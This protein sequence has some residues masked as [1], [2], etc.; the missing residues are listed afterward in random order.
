M[1]LKHF[2]DFSL[3]F[4]NF[5]Q[6]Y[7]DLLYN[8]AQECEFN[9]KKCDFLIFNLFKFQFFLFYE[10]IKFKIAIFLLKKSFHCVIML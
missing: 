5:V 7:E 8:I 10:K 3:I 6:E 2:L 9:F 4:F 1:V